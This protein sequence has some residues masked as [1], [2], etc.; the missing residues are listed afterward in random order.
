[1]KILIANRNYFVTGGPEKYMFSLMENMPEHEF[2]PFCVKFDQNNETLYSK[3]FLEPPG[4]SSNVNFSDFEMSLLQKCRFALNMVYSF[5]ARNKLSVMIEDIKPDIALFLN[6]VHFTDSIIDACKKHNVPIIWRLSD[7]HKICANYLLFRDGKVCD[8]CIENG[9]F[10]IVRNRCGGYQSSLGVS[11]VKYAGMKLSQ[12]RSIHDYINY[13][14]VPSSFTREKRES[15]I[16]I[17]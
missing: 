16:G 8:S 4:G 3:Y 2:V 7:F 12:L 17:L 5:S 14:I 15:P 11:L 10:E 13:F 9:L 6:G 1:M